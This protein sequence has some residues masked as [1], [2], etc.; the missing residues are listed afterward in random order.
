MFTIAA[1]IPKH[2]LPGETLLDHELY[3]RKSIS[4]NRRRSADLS[5]ICGWCR[6]E[7]EFLIVEQN[8]A[9]VL[10]SPGIL[11]SQHFFG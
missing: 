5:R 2:I 10:R 7:I 4:P 3:N 11:S 1:E 6:F 8:K 9:F